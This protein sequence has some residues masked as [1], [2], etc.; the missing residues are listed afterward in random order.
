MKKS[1]KNFPFTIGFLAEK[2]NMSK[3]TVRSWFKQALITSIG[4]N[5][6]GQP[7]FNNKSLREVEIIKGFREAG[8]ELK[9]IKE[10]K[11]KSSLESLEIQL[12]NMA[13]S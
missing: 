3:P 5:E 10:L 4:E 8:Y 9:K 1:I 2:T 6:L 12:K 7:L 13:K 11:K